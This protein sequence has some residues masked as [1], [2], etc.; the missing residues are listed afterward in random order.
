MGYVRKGDR[1]YELTLRKGVKFSD[2]TPLDA[3]AVKTYLDYQRKRNTSSLAVL[4]GRVTSS[5]VT[6]PLTVRI[7][8]VSSDPNLTFSFAQAFGAGY[9]ASPKA[10]AA[11]KTLDQGTAGAGPY[12]L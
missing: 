6:G 9:I 5:K 8:L 4:Q 1:A 11:P 3:Q 2:G 12:M 10:V 7:E